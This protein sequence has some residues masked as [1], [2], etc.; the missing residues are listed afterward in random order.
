MSFEKLFIK[1]VSAQSAVIAEPSPVT[2][3]QTESFSWVTF[4]ISSDIAFVVILVILF[5]LGNLRLRK[6][7]KKIKFEQYKNRELQKR[8]KLALNTM[9]KW[10][11]NPDLIH[12]R[13]WN[14]DYLR[15]R[16]EEE[17]FHHALINQAQIKIQQLIRPALRTNT[18]AKGTVGIANSHGC[19]VDE[20]FD[21]TYDTDVSGKWTKRV[22]FRIQIKLTR[23]PMQSSSKTISE[24]IDCIKTFLSPMEERDNWQPTIQ[25]HVVL[26]SWDQKAKPTPL[27]MLEQYNDGIN[28]RFR[29]N[30]LKRLIL[31]KSF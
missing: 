19:K 11:T 17:V 13:D 27:L 23:L 9:R 14:L 1:P 4:S 24:I 25:G 20:T 7:Q 22:L 12:S 31:P 5:I 8:L 26:M 2:S 29:T 10:E 18:S 30:P 3:P 21:V 16:M 6:S 15:M 28:V